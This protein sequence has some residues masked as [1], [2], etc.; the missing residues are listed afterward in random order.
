M[1]FPLETP[2]IDQNYMLPGSKQKLHLDTQVSNFITE[3]I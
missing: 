2:I 1:D 3:N